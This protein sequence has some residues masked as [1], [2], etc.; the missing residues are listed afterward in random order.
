MRCARRER[1]LGRSAARLLGYSATRLLG[2]SATRLLGYSATRPL[3]RRAADLS[4]RDRVE[5]SA[6]IANAQRR[7]AG[8]AGGARPS[9]Q[10]SGS[11]TAARHVTILDPFLL[12]F[13]EIDNRL[14]LGVL[15]G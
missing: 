5:H 12:R 15:V 10:W 1:L 6:K 14:R 13:A 4:R 9:V 8:V 7:L 11:G 3:G 2:Y